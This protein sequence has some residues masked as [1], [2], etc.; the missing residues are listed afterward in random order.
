MLFDGLY[1]LEPAPESLRF[2]GQVILLVGTNT[3]S[4]GTFPVVFALDNGLATVIGEPCGNGSARYGMVERVKLPNSNLTFQYST[5]IW[6]RARPGA[7]G[8][9]QPIEP[10]VRIVPTLADHL[11]GR[12]PLWD[13][14]VATFVK[15]R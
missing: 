14:F 6:E 7:G 5:R 1:R 9:R 12:D 2:Q 3:F 15:S 4:A 13:Y 11:S 10:N 8:A